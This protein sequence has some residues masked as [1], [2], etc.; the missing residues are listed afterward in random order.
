MYKIGDRV[1]YPMYGAGIIEDIQLKEIDGASVEYY[2]MRIPVGDL[3]ITVSTAK[4][5]QSGFRNVYPAETV[6]NIVKNAETVEMSNNWNLRYKENLA[7]IKTGDLSKIVGIFK[8][9]IFKE[10]S[11][12]LSSI[13]KK[14]M[15]TAKQII[16]SEIIVARNTDKDDAEELLTSGIALPV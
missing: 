14:L 9:L 12:A 16:L 10:R 13:E 11:K 3:K 4:A 2:V 8:T 15:G 7:T 5:E 1:V 6:E